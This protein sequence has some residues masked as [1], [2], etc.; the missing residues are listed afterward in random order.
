MAKELGLTLAETP[1]LLSDGRV[2]GVDGG[3]AP[4]QLARIVSAAFAMEGERQPQLAEIEAGK[5]FAVFDVGVLAV[6]APPP[7][8]AIRNTIASDVQMSKGAAAARSVAQ[9]VQEEVRKG[10]DLATVVAG[11]RLG[12][13]PVQPIDMTR[14]QFQ[15][16][17]QQTPPPLTMLFEMAKGKVKLM[18]APRARGWFVVQLKD[19]IPGKVAANDPRLGE[20]GRSIGQLQSNE[21][22]EQ[23]RAAMRAD[24]TV[25]RNEAAMK[26]L[27]ARLT[28]TGN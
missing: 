18:G 12:L 7:L 5:T 13:P 20:L 22:S 9:K 14:Q 4:P 16:M 17:G 11:L 23:L 10:G 3:Q 2:F 28:G 19:A 1:P 27:R 15:T 25:K 6:S 21:M 8:A 26:A 24:V